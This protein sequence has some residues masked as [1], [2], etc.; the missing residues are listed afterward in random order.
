MCS[1]KVYYD[2]DA[3]REATGRKDVYILRLEQLYP[4]PK[5]A[6]IAELSRFPKAELVWCQEE[7][8]NM[9]AWHFLGENFDEML[10]EMGRDGEKIAYA[11]RKSAA[12]PATGS[13]KKHAIE[14]AALVNEALG[15]APKAAARSRSA[16]KPATRKSPAK[17]KS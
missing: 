14:Q 9:G 4:F 16:S 12:S 10:S 7:P 2:L 17:K 13:A 6:L 11:G 15:E 8:R 5:K 1:G 3:E